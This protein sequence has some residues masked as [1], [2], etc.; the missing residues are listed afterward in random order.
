MEKKLYELLQDKFK[1][2][3]KKMEKTIKVHFLDARK[4]MVADKS[5]WTKE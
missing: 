4:K 5:K 2:R 1:E 3:N